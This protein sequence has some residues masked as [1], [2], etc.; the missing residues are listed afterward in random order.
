MPLVF[1]AVSAVL[2]IGL[3]FL[4]IFIKA[5]ETAIIA[6]SVRYLRIEGAFYFGIG[7]LF[8]LSYLL[9]TILPI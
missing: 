2:N 5:E 1:L 8:L 6:E 9:S 7:C 3:D 4:F